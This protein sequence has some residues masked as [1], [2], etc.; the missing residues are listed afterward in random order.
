MDFWQTGLDCLSRPGEDEVV[1]TEVPFL[2]HYLKGHSQLF[3]KLYLIFAGSRNPEIGGFGVDFDCC[4]LY[5]V[6][7]YLIDPVDSDQ[8]I[9]LT[10]CRSRK[11]K[12]TE[13]E[14]NRE[15]LH[16]ISF[17]D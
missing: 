15:L 13:N 4:S 7:D 3:E 17:V 1:L 6:N 5:L 9:R 12:K 2:I 14:G 16:H 11:Q 10:P 8:I